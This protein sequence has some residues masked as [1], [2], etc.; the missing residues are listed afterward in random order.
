MV[1]IVFCSITK[2]FQRN[3]GV[4]LQSAAEAIRAAARRH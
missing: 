3:A 2:V 1:R 4:A